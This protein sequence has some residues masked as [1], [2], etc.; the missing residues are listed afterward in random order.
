MGFGPRLGCTVRLGTSP[1]AFH[2]PQPD[3]TAETRQVPHV[4]RPPLMRDRPRPT[5]RTADHLGGGLDRDHQL[6]GIL[7]H[8]EDPQFVQSQHGLGQTGTVCHRQGPPSCCCHEQLQTMARPLTASQ[9]P[10]RHLNPYSSRKS[11]D[12]PAARVGDVPSFPETRYIGSGYPQLNRPSQGFPAGVSGL[13]PGAAGT[14]IYDIAWR[15]SSS[16][17]F[18]S[19]AVANRSSRL[20]ADALTRNLARSPLRSA[21][22][23]R[24]SLT[25]SPTIGL[26][27]S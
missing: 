13:P 14:R 8:L 22:M 27:P 10:Q 18:I 9:D 16:A 20:G 24:G 23:E 6:V 2:H 19:C 25:S 26:P 15:T 17:T 3:R 11:L 4:D 12:S 21:R 1:A 5:P 7:G